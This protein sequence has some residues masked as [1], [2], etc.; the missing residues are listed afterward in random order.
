MD[1]GELP[2]QSSL[3]VEQASG[4]ISAIELDGREDQTEIKSDPT[5]NEQ[6]VRTA[7]A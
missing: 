1:S 5:I 2:C 7:Q 4:E 3:A 6:S